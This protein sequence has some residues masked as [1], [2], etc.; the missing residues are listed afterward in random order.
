VWGSGRSILIYLAGLKEIPSQL[1][2]AAE[3]DGANAWRRMVHVTIPL[4]TP[5]IL[6]NM[7]TMLIGSLQSFVGP[8]IMTGGGPANSTLLYGLYLYRRAFLN[9][10]MGLASAMAWIL[11]IVILVLTLLMLRVSQRVVVYDR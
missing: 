11:F 9:M 3:I 4:L 6:F 8:F 1:Y 5:Q 2:E 10:R 7:I